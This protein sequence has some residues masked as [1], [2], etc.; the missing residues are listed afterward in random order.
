MASVLEDLEK[1]MAAA[2]KKALSS[3]P[4]ANA[5]KAFGR[6]QVRSLL[7]ILKKEKS[8]GEGASYGSL[9]EIMDLFNQELKNPEAQHVA[10]SSASRG[11]VPSAMTMGQAKNPMFLASL[12]L[13]LQVDEVCTHKNHPG[14]LFK[15]TKVDENG[16]QIK[17]QD[18]VPSYEELMYLK[19]R[20]WT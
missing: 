20:L 10:A 5:F 2:W 13:K 18:P 17:F 12:K 14:K 3:S 15:I 8:G 4:Q 16:V 9:D 19:E 7:H 6:F 1:R 11:F